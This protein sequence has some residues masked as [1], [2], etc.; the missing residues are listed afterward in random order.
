MTNEEFSAPCLAMATIYKST[1]HYVLFRD[2]HNLAVGH[3][4]IMTKLVSV[5]IFVYSYSYTFVL[6]VDTYGRYDTRRMRPIEK[7]KKKHH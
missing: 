5:E 4:I 6:R 3:N 7:N 2:H 1:G